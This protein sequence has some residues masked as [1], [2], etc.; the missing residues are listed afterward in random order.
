M[1]YGGSFGVR[2]GGGGGRSR[3][4]WAV[5]EKV[6]L[7]STN[8]KIGKFKFWYCFYTWAGTDSKFSQPLDLE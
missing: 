8:T 4:L 6:N 7:E 1:G 5:L 2:N 3:S